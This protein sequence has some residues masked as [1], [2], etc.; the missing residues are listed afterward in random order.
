MKAANGP[1]IEYELVYCLFRKKIH[2]LKSDGFW[3]CDGKRRGILI[4]E[5]NSGWHAL[6]ENYLTWKHGNALKPEVE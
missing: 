1:L 4:R 3:S 6:P 5:N 2:S